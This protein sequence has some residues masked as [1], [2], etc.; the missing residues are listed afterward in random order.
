[1]LKK[2]KQLCPICNESNQKKKMQSFSLNDTTVT[3]SRVT[4]NGSM[5]RRRR[6]CTCGSGYRF[7][8]YERIHRPEL[9]VVKRNGQIIPFNK[10]RIFQS[11]KVA[12]NG[13]IDQEKKTEQISNEVNEKIQ[14]IGKDSVPTKTIG[15]FILKALKERDKIGYVRFYGVFKKVNDPKE[16]KRIVDTLH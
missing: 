14:D 16:Y 7:T 6:L 13:C 11:V 12:L 5:I 15:E 8:T 3:D 4:K 2:N 10:E 1:M 9:T